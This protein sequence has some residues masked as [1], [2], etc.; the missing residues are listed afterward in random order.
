M[1]TK[2]SKSAAAAAE[3]TTK[4]TVEK[5]RALLLEAEA[6][7]V[8]IEKDSREAEKLGHAIG[9]A[10]WATTKAIGFTRGPGR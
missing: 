4:Q 1:S 6:L 9:D 5:I 3:P 10:V 2:P 8:G 7:A